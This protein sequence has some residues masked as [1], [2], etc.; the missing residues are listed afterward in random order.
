M[1]KKKASGLEMLAQVMAQMA[2]DRAAA[3]EKFK[4]QWAG[5]DRSP[6]DVPTVWTAP[7]TKG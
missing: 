5:S 6:S 4:P 2:V 7:A 1:T 3:A